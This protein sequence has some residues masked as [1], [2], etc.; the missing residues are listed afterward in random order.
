MKANVASEQSESC[1]ICKPLGEPVPETSELAHLFL[2]DLP[3]LFRDRHQ[4]PMPFGT[5]VFPRSHWYPFGNSK[6]PNVAPE[7]RGDLRRDV[8]DVRAA[9]RRE[10]N[11]IGNESHS[12]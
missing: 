1:K 5:F 4:P 6:P 11:R 2:I 12:D 10:R 7:P 8:A 9:E 3:S